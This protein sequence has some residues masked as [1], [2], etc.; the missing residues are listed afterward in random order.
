MVDKRRHHIDR[1]ILGLA[2]LDCRAVLECILLAAQV[3]ALLLDSYRHRLGEGHALAER[4][5][6]KALNVRLGIG[7]H[8][9][10]AV[11]IGY[12]LLSVVC[13]LPLD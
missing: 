9:C 6:Y 7:N 3:V 1:V 5:D 12:N 13:A 11:K 2:E 4:I 10:E 8:L